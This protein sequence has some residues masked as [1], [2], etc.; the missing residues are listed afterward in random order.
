MSLSSAKTV[1]V[2]DTSI[3]CVWLKVPG[4]ETCGP[5]IDRWDF[6]RVDHD[7]QRHIATGSSLI[8]PLTT[9]IETGNHIA[10]AV[11]DRYPV[12][13]ELAKIMGRAADAES[14][15]AAFSEQA[16]GWTPENLKRLAQ[17]WP[18]LAAQKMSIGDATIKDVADYYAKMG[19]KVTLLTGD[20]QLAAYQPAAPAMIPRRRK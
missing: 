13:I 8:L 9:I 20:Q 2:I 12:A 11:G 3:L 6:A 17:D 16:E 5:D 10:Q 19:C 1:V 18:P 14:P 7:I 4:L 15:W